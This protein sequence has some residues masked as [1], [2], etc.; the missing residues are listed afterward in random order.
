VSHEARLSAAAN[1]YDVSSDGQKF[2]MIKSPISLA[3]LMKCRWRV[4]KL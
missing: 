1:F 4:D 3:S 2:L